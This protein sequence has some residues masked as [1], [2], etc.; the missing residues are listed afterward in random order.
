MPK[1][2]GMR[3]IVE[4]HRYLRESQMVMKAMFLSLGLESRCILDKD[5]LDLISRKLRY[6]GLVLAS[7]HVAERDLKLPDKVL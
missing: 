1:S 2:W 5:F 4:T 6:P 7:P 3:R